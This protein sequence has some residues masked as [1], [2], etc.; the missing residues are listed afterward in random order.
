MRFV[1]ASV[2]AVLLSSPVYAVEPAT[3]T[4]T[5]PAPAA[6]TNTA[7]VADSQW[8]YSCTR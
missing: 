7:A 4:P 6:V 3:T 1:V 5:A 2:V 8:G